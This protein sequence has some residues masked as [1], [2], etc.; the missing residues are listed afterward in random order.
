MEW[1]GPE[2]L[3]HTLQRPGRPPTEN[4][5]VLMSAV[6]KLRNPGAEGAHGGLGQPPG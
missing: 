5:T 6:L 4:N 2:M 1:M 3:L